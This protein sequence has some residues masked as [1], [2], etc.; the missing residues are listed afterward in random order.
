M[1][2]NPSQAELLQREFVQKKK[3]L[4]DSKKK[5]LMEKYLDGQMN[6]QMDPRLRLGLVA[7]SLLLFLHFLQ[8][9]RS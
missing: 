4:E 7:P 3:V 1:I 9:I 8:F 6:E 2:S 5:A